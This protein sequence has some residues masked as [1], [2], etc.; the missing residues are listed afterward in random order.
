[1]I[2]KYCSTFL[3]AISLCCCSNASSTTETVKNTSEESITPTNNISENDRTSTKFD[4]SFTYTNDGSTLQINLLPDGSYLLNISLFRLAGFDDATGHAANDTLSFTTTTP[5][6]TPLKGV[7]VCKGDT[8]I[9]TFTESTWEYIP[10]GSTYQF[11]RDPEATVHTREFLVGKTFSGYGNGG[12][13]GIEVT[14]TFED[15]GICQCTSDFYQ[16]FTQ[17]VTI[18]GSYSVSYNNIV[19]VMCRPDG[20]EAPICWYFNVSD[21]NT[22]LSFNGSGPDDEGSIVKDWLTLRLK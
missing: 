19:E 8:A 22:Q 13:L 2:L 21:Y 3:I 12:G 6:M 20:F 7:V 5:A 9:L 1:M 16:A 18:N 14:I 17:P 11:V 4:G 15:D 10:V